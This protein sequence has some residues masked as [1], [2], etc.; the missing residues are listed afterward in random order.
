HARASAGTRADSAANINASATAPTVVSAM[1]MMLIGPIEASE[2]GRVKMPTPMMLPRIS[3]V[4]WGNPSLGPVSAVDCA[5]PGLIS[6]MIP[7]GG[8]IR[9]HPWLTV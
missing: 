4:A 5:A 6:T 7:P 3:A 2:Y 9:K 1:A 8:Q